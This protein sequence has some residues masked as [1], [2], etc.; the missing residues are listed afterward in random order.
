MGKLDDFGT[1]DEG[2]RADLILVERDPL[3]DVS[4][5]QDRSGVMLG[6]RWM[7]E[8]QLQSM[9][10]GLVE[11]YKPN[12]FERLWPLLL[13]GAAIYMLRRKLT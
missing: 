7:T 4:R 12:L 6:G 13:I 3:R 8:D 11:S 2:K 9:L 10:D 5:L 1:I